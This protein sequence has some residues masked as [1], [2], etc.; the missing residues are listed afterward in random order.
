[1]TS[2]PPRTSAG[3]THE[4]IVFITGFLVGLA[5][6]PVQMQQIE[7]VTSTV[8]MIQSVLIW[9]VHPGPHGSATLAAVSW[10]SITR[11]STQ[12][13]RLR[14]AHNSSARRRE[15]IPEPAVARLYGSLRRGRSRVGLEDGDPAGRSQQIDGAVG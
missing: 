9:L 2:Q 7:F 1:M 8:R 13:R 3:Q 4:G 14:G 15:G 10:I 6:P 5:P 12:S 11:S